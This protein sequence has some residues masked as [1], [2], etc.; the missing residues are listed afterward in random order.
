MS[1][2]D[3]Y[4]KK[5]EAKLIAWNVEIDKLVDRAEGLKADTRLKFRERIEKIRDKRQKAKTRLKALQ[6]ASGDAWDDLK[7]GVDE[8]FDALGDAVKSARSEF[9]ESKK[10]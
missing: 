7:E 1:K 10:H 4:Q 8:A 6:S 2:K 3:A 5:L 9:R